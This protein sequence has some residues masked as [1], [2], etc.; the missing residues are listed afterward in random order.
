M[1]WRL[2]SLRIEQVTA[3]MFIKQYAID[4]HAVITQGTHY[5]VGLMITLYLGRWVFKKNTTFDF[6]L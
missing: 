2:P 3:I 6:Y 5:V 1:R 4:E